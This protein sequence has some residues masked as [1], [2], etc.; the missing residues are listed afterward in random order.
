[1]LDGECMKDLM[2]GTNSAV[3]VLEAGGVGEERS[4]ESGP[5]E[6]A[7]DVSK[8]PFSSGYGDR[9]SNGDMARPITCHQCLFRSGGYGAYSRKMDLGTRCT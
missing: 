7:T 2:I 4:S 9:V 8:V 1:M 3:E 5:S 6:G